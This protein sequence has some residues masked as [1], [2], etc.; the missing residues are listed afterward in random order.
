MT[1]SVDDEVTLVEVM[2][3][4]LGVAITWAVFYGSD[5][6]ELPGEASNPDP[7][8]TAEFDHFA[9]GRTLR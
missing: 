1:L 8:E 5:T 6:A 3:L 4:L 7:H 2:L 9:D